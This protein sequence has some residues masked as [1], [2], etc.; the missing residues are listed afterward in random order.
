M[1]LD[2]TNLVE[3]SN[4]L[5]NHQTA[6]L[7]GNPTF[8]VINSV[9]WSGQATFRG[10]TL[11]VR[12][13]D[14]VR[15]GNGSVQSVNQGLSVHLTNCGYNGIRNG[16]L[17]VSQIG[18]LSGDRPGMSPTFR[19]KEL[20]HTPMALPARGLEQNRQTMEIAFD[21]SPSEIRVEFIWEDE[22]LHTDLAVYSFNVD[23]RDYL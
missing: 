16:E 1:F 2:I 5:N 20:L 21:P 8:V 13:G 12:S 4:E 7:Y 9:L 17:R 23:F 3:E 22:G 11:S 14:I 18:V 6:R 10:G 15:W 19:T